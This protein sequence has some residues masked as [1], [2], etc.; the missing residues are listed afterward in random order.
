MKDS[1]PIKLTEIDAI[2]TKKNDQHLPRKTQTSGDSRH[3]RRYEMIKIAISRRREL[4][5]AEADV[6]ERLVVDAEC[7]VRIFDQLMYR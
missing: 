5:D 3:G 4:Q 7:L 2:T 1:L 6:V